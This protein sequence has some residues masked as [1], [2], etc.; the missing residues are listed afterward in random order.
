MIEWPLVFLGGFLGSAHCLGMCGA[1]AVSIGL[2]APGPLGNL[3]R[4]IVYTLGR[5]F[6]YSFLGAVAGF[7]GMRLVHLSV[8]FVNLQALLAVVA[9]GL[10]ILQGLWSAGL[11]PRVLFFSGRAAACPGNSAFSTFLSSPNLQDVFLAGLL[12]GFLPCG[13][14]YA[15]LT[16]AA[17]TGSLWI[18]ASTMALFGA[19]TA[20]AMILTGIGATVF[21][22][23]SRRHLFRLAAVCVIL[24]GLLTLARG[25]VAAQSARASNQSSPTAC[26]LCAQ[27]PTESHGLSDSKDSS[28]AF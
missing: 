18:A 7:A 22:L 21:N 15:F 28:A 4:Q 5:V 12:T 14:V 10:L 17:S 6:T 19:G 20:P 8:E 25:I 2:G 13:L 3:Q 23:T 27:N 9:G 16:L 1:L 26:P 11:L 24:T